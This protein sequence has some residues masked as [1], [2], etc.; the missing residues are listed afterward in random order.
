MN[1]GIYQIVNTAN[2]KQYI[3]SAVDFGG[4][5]KA[6]RHQ[7][8]H[9]AHHSRHLQ[10]AWNKYGEA[11]FSFRKLLVCAK[12]DLVMYEQRAFDSFHPEYNIARFAGSNLGVEQSAE[13]R[14]KRARS[15]LGNKN[16]CGVSPSAETRAKISAKSAGKKHALGCKHS[17]EANARK[18]L[19]Q[20][21]NKH[22]L[23]KKHTPE[24]IAQIAAWSLGRKH[25]VESR[26]KLSLAHTGKILSAETK[27]KIVAIRTGSKASPEARANMRAAQAS[28][29]AREKQGST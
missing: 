1:T 9:N 21:G 15:L 4:R 12:E 27:A 3:G 26:A 6:H 14:S 24:R 8:R 11:A 2:G 10:F 20:I 13:T 28:R 19:L 7:L 22:R 29:R 5:W 17:P 23:G 25:T 16:S 18:S